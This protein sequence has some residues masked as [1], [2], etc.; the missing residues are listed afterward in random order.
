MSKPNQLNF[1]KKHLLIE[2]TLY[3]ILAV[4]AIAFFGRIAL[5]EH[6]YYGRMEGSPRA[7]ATNNA[8][9]APLEVEEVDETPVTE[10]ARA[11]Y[12]V[13]ADYPRY[14]SVP[15]LGIVNARVLQMGITATGE[16][17]TPYNVFDIGWYTSSSKPGFGGTLLMDG[18]NGGPNV[19]GIFKYLNTLEAGDLLTVER[20]DGAIFNYR[21]VENLEIALDEADS[22]MATAM[23][24]AVP[25][26]EGLTL[27]SCIGEW[28]QIRQT[29]LSRQFV[30]AVLADS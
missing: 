19:I 4:L 11:E 15:K 14:L 5:W 22:Y 21:V 16:L 29:Y 20:G 13:P 28:S 9:S 27:I 18:H 3:S 26:Q 17:D 10:E 8:E 24:S 7:V 2:R 12:V 1:T 30:R 6:D 23:T 25:G